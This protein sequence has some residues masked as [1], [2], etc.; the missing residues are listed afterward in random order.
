MMSFDRDFVTLRIR[1]CVTKT[2][3]V[4]DLFNTQLG[5][6]LRKVLH[7]PS[8]LFDLILSQ[9]RQGSEIRLTQRHLLFS[10][11]FLAHLIFKTQATY[12]TAVAKLDWYLETVN[13]LRVLTKNSEC[14]ENFRL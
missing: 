14:I 13:F 10:S 1:S 4:L 8:H 3:V 6:N 11:Y 2:R 7:L 9:G 12:T 5:F